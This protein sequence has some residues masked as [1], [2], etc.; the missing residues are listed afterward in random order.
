MGQSILQQVK[1]YNDIYAPEYG[2]IMYTQIASQGRRTGAS[3][4]NNIT[5]IASFDKVSAKLLFDMNARFEETLDAK[6]TGDAMSLDIPLPLLTEKFACKTKTKHV[7]CNACDENATS[8]TKENVTSV[9]A[10]GLLG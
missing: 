6:I 4:A 5:K 8:C 10:I 3:V 2:D 7:L 9:A 1:D